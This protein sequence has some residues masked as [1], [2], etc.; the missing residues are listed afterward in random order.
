M[1]TIQGIGLSSTTPKKQYSLERFLSFY[2]R[3]AFNVI[4]KFR[5]S[6]VFHYYD[7]N[8]GSG[9][10]DGKSG[11]PLI[12][13]E[14]L[15]RILPEIDPQNQIKIEA[16]FVEI[17]KQNVRDLEKNISTLPILRKVVARVLCGDNKEVIQ[18]FSFPWGVG[19]LYHDPNGCFN[20]DMLRKFA[21]KNKRIDL[22]V[23][24]NSVAQKRSEKAHGTLCLCD[25][26]QTIPK[27]RWLI[28]ENGGKHQWA[29]LFGSNWIGFPAYKRE[30]FFE[31]ESH[32]GEKIWE[33]I[34]LTEKERME[35]F[36][37]SFEFMQLGW[38][39]YEDYLAS[40]E[41]GKIRAQ[42]HRMAN[43]KCEICGKPST[44]VHHLRYT[45]W[46]NGQ[47]DTVENIRSL[48]HKC[49]CES[50]GKEN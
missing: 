4:K 37:P 8:A 40:K 29:F 31:L 23:N 47:V 17:D 27:D 38:D 15:Q 13:L 39:T 26:V 33:H 2:L 49:H 12:F 32:E 6:Q 7:V 36:Q 46:A 42:R 25:A 35:K 16:T 14:T 10:V 11:S 18:N 28:R 20:H 30:G 34:S 1:P 21:E 22:L 44:E 43:H 3:I 41:F 24:C 45:D 50:H 19:L 48:C 5:G 9:K